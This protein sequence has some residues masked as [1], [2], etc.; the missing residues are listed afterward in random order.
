MPDPREGART[1]AG[2]A[3][4]VCDGLAPRRQGSSKRQCD[5][6]GERDSQQPDPGSERRICGSFRQ[7]RRQVRVSCYDQCH[8]PMLISAA[9][10]TLVTSPTIRIVVSPENTPTVTSER[11]TRS[12]ESPAATA[13]RLSFTHASL[14]RYRCP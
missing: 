2:E 4:A 3:P 14:G 8:V 1:T 13:T 5:S 6:H 11:A 7:V 9:D 10:G 12:A